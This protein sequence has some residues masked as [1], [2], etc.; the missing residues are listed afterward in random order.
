[1]SLADLLR[2]PLR[3]VSRFVTQCENFSNQSAID[4]KFSDDVKRGIGLGV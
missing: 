3:G 4:I 1:M 2:S